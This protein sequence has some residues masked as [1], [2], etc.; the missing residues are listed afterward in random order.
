MVEENTTISGSIRD[1]ALYYISI[2]LPV[3]PLCSP[4]HKGM[5][6]AHMSKCKSPGKAPL[7]K[8]W[9][10]WNGTSREDVLEWFRNAK[11][12]GA[13]INIGIPLGS[14]SNMI[15]LDIDGEQ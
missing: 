12:R 15:G 9:S 4:T 1:E 11:Q 6:V 7:L 13:N 10:N 8:D 2:G 14:N 3:I 5:S